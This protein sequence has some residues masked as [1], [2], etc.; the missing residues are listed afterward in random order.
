MAFEQQHWKVISWQMH[1][2]KAKISQCICSVWSVSAWRNF[3]FLAIQNVPSKDSDQTGKC[4]GWPE[5][6]LGAHVEGTFSEVAAHLEIAFSAL[7]VKLYAASLI[8][9]CGLHN[10]QWI[11]SH[12]KTSREDW[13]TVRTSRLIQVLTGCIFH[14]IFSHFTVHMFKPVCFFTVWMWQLL[15][16]R[17]TII[18]WKSE[19]TSG[20]NK[21]CMSW[22]FFSLDCRK[23]SLFLWE[24]LS[25]YLFK[26]VWL[27][28]AGKVC[29]NSW[30]LSNI[31]QHVNFKIWCKWIWQSHIAWESTEDEISHLDTVWR[32]DITEWIMIIT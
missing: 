22:K 14:C 2:M 30:R 27:N 18:I 21:I 12:Q 24:G 7:Q 13:P 19:Q 17:H 15:S 11:L 9:H 5:S 3:A 1:P 8:C 16:G 25:T 23:K 10:K 28:H 31:C 20:W 26:G 4:R 32:Y 6:S 29:E